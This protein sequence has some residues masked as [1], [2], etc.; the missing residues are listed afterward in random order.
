[1]KSHRG[2]F[3]SHSRSAFAFAIAGMIFFA[4]HWIANGPAAAHSRIQFPGQSQGGLQLPLQPPV[5]HPVTAPVPVAPRTPE[6]PAPQRLTTPKLDPSVKNEMIERRS[7]EMQRNGVCR[8]LEQRRAEL[9]QQRH[10][11]RHNEAQ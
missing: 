2:F 4:S 6:V 3:A 11:T 5:Q 7:Q 10:S 1:M 8:K 9:R